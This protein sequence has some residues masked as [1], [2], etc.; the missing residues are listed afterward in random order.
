V[1]ELRTVGIERLWMRNG[2]YDLYDMGYLLGY[3]GDAWDQMRQHSGLWRQDGQVILKN[4]SKYLHGTTNE[5]RN[6]RI[7]GSN[8]V[9]FRLVLQE[10]T[11]D[12]SKVVLKVG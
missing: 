12:S 4:F 3:S 10:S 5:S 2:E 7:G 11:V 9:W 6:L 1:G 8:K